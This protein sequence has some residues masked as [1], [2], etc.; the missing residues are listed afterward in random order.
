MVTLQD[1]YF[2]CSDH[3]KMQTFR[4]ILIPTDF[5][6]AAWNAVQLGLELADPDTTVITLLHVFPSGARFNRK[7]K[8]HDIEELDDFKGIKQQMDDL[9]ADFSK[10]RKVTLQPVILVG[11]VEEEICEYIEDNDFDLVIMGV[12]SNGQDN[13][14]G[15][16]TSVIIARCCV[17]V[18]VVPNRKF[19]HQPQAM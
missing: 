4:N 14:P 12:N 2:C 17:P 8:Q 7:K 13:E 18:L 10:D 15:S 5:S 11:S 6:H 3:I 19:S 9:C 1:L 16:H